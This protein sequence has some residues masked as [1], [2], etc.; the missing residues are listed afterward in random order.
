MTV[1]TIY[2]T[3]DE[4]LNEASNSPAIRRRIEDDVINVAMFVQPDR[5]HVYQ[6]NDHEP[7]ATLRFGGPYSGAIWIGDELTGEYHKDTNGQF[8]VIDIA[9]GFRKPDSRRQQDPL[10]HLL[11]VLR[12]KLGSA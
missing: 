1:N 10:V 8:V 4:L 6:G 5:I 3:I 9:S 2:P 7:F 11:E 12:E